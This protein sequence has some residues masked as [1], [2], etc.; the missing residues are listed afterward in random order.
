[1]RNR[2]E[3]SALSMRLASDITRDSNEPSSRFDVTSETMS[4]NFISCSRLFFMLSTNCV[5]CNATAAWVVMASSN[6]RSSSLKASPFF[7]FR[8]CTTPMIS[9][10][11]V[12]TGA[13]QMVSV[14]NPVCSSTEQ[15]AR[16]EGI[17]EIKQLKDTAAALREEMEQLN[18]ARQKEVQEERAAGNDEITQLKNTIQALRDEME[19]LKL[20]KEK[21]LNEAVSAGRDEIQQLKATVAHLRQEMEDLNFRHQET[22]QE[23][24][25]TRRDEVGE[26]QQA[27]VTLRRT[28]EVKSQRG[29][30][31]RQ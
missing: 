9:S 8:H 31:A 12:F 18:F 11:T 14:L 15:E 10:F 30:E 20:E 17:D 2:V 3:R 21:E 4:R 29:S 26:L 5:L 28:L 6:A 25:R 13:A 23:L 1:L 22:V 16:A 7:L 24:N 27:I 19:T